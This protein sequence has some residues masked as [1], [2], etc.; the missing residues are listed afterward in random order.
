MPYKPTADTALHALDPIQLAA[1]QNG[2]AWTDGLSVSLSSTTAII[3]TILQPGTVIYEG[4]TISI[5]NI[6]VE[7]QDGDGTHPRW[8]AICVTDRTGTVEAISGIPAEPVTLSDGTTIRGKRA[9]KPAPPDAVTDDMVCLALVWIPSGATQNSDLT[10]TSAGGVSNPILDRRVANSANISHVTRRAVIDSSGWYRIAGIGALSPGGGGAGS[11]A[12]T[13]TVRDTQSGEHSTATLDAS[14]L[15][16]DPALTLWNST[17][18]TEP[19]GAIEGAR[20]VTGSTNAGA[21]LDIN[22]Q[23]G[24]KP[25][26]D[27]VEYAIS[28]EQFEPGWSPMEFESAS[29]PSGFEATEIDFTQSPLF[30]GAKLNN[31]PFQ[32]LGDG[33]VAMSDIERET[34]GV[35]V[36]MTS[37]QDIPPTTQTDLAFNRTV[38]DDY[39]AFD[40]DLNQFFIPKGGTYHIEASAIWQTVPDAVE[41]KM[42]MNNG[43]EEII[44]ASR[45]TLDTYPTT[46]ISGTARLGADDSVKTSVI[47]SNTSDT[48]RVL[49]DAEQTWMT[50]TRIG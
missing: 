27:F 45:A 10:D 38:Y 28:H 11:A 32:V 49:A 43:N 5:G 22:V 30:A 12:A 31:T 2:Y 47:L 35:K 29:I 9:Y 1:A 17:A 34:V 33:T 26:I 44:A 36:N 4:E 13:V 41:V 20:I 40:T 48:Q 21:G 24:G 7:H 16:S 3:E 15:F 46:T 42:T 8:D 19:H 23:L 50:V 18:F 37:A 14:V 25:Q 39:G 6:T